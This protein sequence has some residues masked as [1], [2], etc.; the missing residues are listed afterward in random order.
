MDTNPSNET[1]LS[2]P[3]IAKVIRDKATYNA[4]RTPMDLPI[5]QEVISAVRSARG[6]VVSRALDGAEVER[7][8]DDLSLTDG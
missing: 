6:D 2:H 7:V 3:D 8:R 4:V 5:A 1:L